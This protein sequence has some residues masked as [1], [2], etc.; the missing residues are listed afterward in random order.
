MQTLVSAL[1]A[2]VHAQEHVPICSVVLDQDHAESS[3]G[4]G[5]MVEEEDLP[6]RECHI[7]MDA[8]V[9]VQSATCAH[10]MCIPCAKAVCRCCSLTLVP[11]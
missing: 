8:E 9:E 10:R 3:D 2:L 1:E 6:D 5:V 7:C 11:P 4:S